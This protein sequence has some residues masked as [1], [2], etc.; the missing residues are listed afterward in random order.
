MNQSG[1]ENAVEGVLMYLNSENQ[2]VIEST[3]TFGVIFC[4]MATA[5]S[6]TAVGSYGDV[7]KGKTGSGLKRGDGNSAVCCSAR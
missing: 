4:E 7:N 2:S 6:K 3:E 5:D 1:Q